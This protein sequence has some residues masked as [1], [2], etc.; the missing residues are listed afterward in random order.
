MN[1]STLKNLAD[2]P[3]SQLLTQLQESPNLKARR[4]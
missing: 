2:L 3:A 1:A 4:A